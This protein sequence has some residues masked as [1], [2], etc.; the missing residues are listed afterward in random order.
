MIQQFNSKLIPWK[1][2]QARKKVMEPIVIA[3]ESFGNYWR[4]WSEVYGR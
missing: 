1:M 3:L 4:T 2:A